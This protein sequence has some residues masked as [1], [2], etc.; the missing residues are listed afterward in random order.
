MGKIFCF[1]NQKGGVGKTTTAVNL[2]A[3]CGLNGIKTLLIDIDPQGNSTSGFGIDRNILES[4]TYDFIIGNKS[5][6]NSIIN[7]NIGNVFISPANSN[8]AAA[9]IELIEASEREFILKK[10]LAEIE[11]EYEVILMDCPPSLGLLTINSLVAS[12]NLLI[13]LQCEYYSLEGLGQLINTFNLVKQNLNPNLEIG[14]VIL[15][16]ADFRAS[17]TKQVIEE[18]RN[19][20]GEKVFQTIIPRSVKVSE[21]P[22]FGKP[23]VLYDASSKAAKAYLELGGEFINRFS[24]SKTSSESIPEETISIDQN[25]QQAEP[26]AE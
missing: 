3:I 25:S 4:T 12:Q 20:F 10:A 8:L 18:V 14:G 21:A 1:S 15:T 2:A 6:K 17:L 23:V 26:V 11:S 24:F 16:M 13:P 19:Y 7:T 22:S 5:I 9:E